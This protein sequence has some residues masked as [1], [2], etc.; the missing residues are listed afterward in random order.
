MESATRV[1]PR[2]TFYIGL[3]GAITYLVYFL[4]YVVLTR[5]LTPIEIGKLPLL[6]AALAVYGT[7]TILSL[8][9]ATTKF[10][11]EYAG[12]GRLGL[13]S[14]VGWISIKLVAAVTL[15]AFILLAFISPQLSELIF[16][17]PLDAS[18]LKLT[19]LAASISNFGIILVSVLWGLNLFS[20]M[21]ASNLA[22]IIAGRICGILLAWVGLKLP[23]F[24]VGWVLGSATTLVLLAVYARPYLKRSGQDVATRQLLAY[25]YPLLLASLI[26]LVQSWADVTILYALTRNL[27]ATGVYYLAF[28]GSNILSIIATALTSAIFPTLS[29]MYGRAETESFKEALRVAQ[30]VLNV[31]VLPTGVALAAVAST[32]V[33]VAYG[34][35]YLA[36]VVPFAILTASSIIPA[37]LLLMTDVLQS[38][39][40][41]K[42]L[43][44][45][46]AASALTEVALTAVLVPPLNVT[47]SAVARLGMSVVGLLLTYIFVKGAWWPSTDRTSL[48]KSLALSVIVGL[49][50]LTFDSLMIITTRTSPLSRI[51]L[52]GAAFLFVYVV[53]L[54]ALKPLI[55]QDIEILTAALPSNLHGLLRVV[56]RWLTP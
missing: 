36:A 21:V 40:R 34:K 3:Q 37:Y 22:G 28:A 1:V 41:T 7:V 27:V 4:S 14:S 18:L 54:I 35:A 52:D 24:I 53:G 10:V 13:A 12:S 29:A 17:S 26:A 56:E 43:M 51:L 48:G 23:G 42:P 44:K 47:G 38:I 2:G 50:M 9:T 25:S 39:G 5:I 49:V 8:Q 6:N 31:L 46:A 45:I 19:L 33:T 30:R 32:A 11:S 16:G 20:S 15:P 55:P